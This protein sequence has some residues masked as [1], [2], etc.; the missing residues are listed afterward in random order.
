MQTSK[1]IDGKWMA[2]GI[3]NGKEVLKLKI[4]LATCKINACIVLPSVPK[5][6]RVRLAVGLVN[7]K[8]NDD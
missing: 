3:P 2:A 8:T 1:E 4:K 6:G 7:E 5:S